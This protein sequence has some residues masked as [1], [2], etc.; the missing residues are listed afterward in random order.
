MQKVGRYLSLFGVTLSSSAAI[1][2]LAEVN[3]TSAPRC[4]SGESCYRQYNTHLTPHLFVL[5]SITFI[6]IFGKFEVLL[7]ALKKYRWDLLISFTKLVEH[8]SLK[9][10]K[11]CSVTHIV[12][13]FVMPYRSK[14]LLRQRKMLSQWVSRESQGRWAQSVWQTCKFNTYVFNSSPTTQHHDINEQKTAVLVITM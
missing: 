4:V 5:Y 12:V 7:C 14:R 11:K 6:T 8:I 13:K 9:T 3:T 10:F 1:V 2:L